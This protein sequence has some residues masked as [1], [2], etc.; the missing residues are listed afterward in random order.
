MLAA[1]PVKLSVSNAMLLV[2]MPTM[3]LGLTWSL[4]SPVNSAEEL[5]LKVMS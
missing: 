2:G 3:P 5:A 4:N 1:V